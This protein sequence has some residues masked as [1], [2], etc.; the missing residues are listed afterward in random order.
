MLRFS[1]A[2]LAVCALVALATPAAAQGP[3]AQDQPKAVK[4]TDTI[5]MAH[6]GA[7]VYLVMTPDGNVVIDA[8]A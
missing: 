6:A 2:A 3:A 4:I 7:N 5:Y 8:F 1:D